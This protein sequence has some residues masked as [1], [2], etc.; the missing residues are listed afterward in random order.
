M[1]K[2]KKIRWN[3]I[4]YIVLLLLAGALLYHVCKSSIQASMSFVIG[5]DFVGEYRQ[6]DGDWQPLDKDTKLSAFGGDVILR[7]QLSEQLPFAVSYYLNHIGVS[8]MVNGELV[9]ESGRITDAL[10]KEMCG[11]YWNSWLYDGEEPIQEIEI[12]LHNP[13]H[14]G[15]ANAFNQFLDSL[16]FG[17]GDA[18]SKHLNS[19]SLPYQIIGSFVMLVAIAILGTVVGYFA[20]RLPS[21]GILGSA[22]L[23]SLFMGLYIWMD[24]VDI[25][26]RSR[27]IIFNTGIR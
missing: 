1:K 10:L 7:G 20:Q 17:G 26:F 6:G 14:Y 5:I 19:E 4:G 16:H 25:E 18:L 11:S 22:G 9:T 13:H 27:E 3:V 23:L 21:A 2:I 12:R 15:N 8:V 24:T